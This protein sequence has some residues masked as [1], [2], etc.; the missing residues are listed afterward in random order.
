[1]EMSCYV[2]LVDCYV[3]VS[4]NVMRVLCDCLPFFGCKGFVCKIRRIKNV[5]D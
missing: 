2:V 4:V 3:V 5:H 1:M